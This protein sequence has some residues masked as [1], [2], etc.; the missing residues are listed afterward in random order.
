M[1]EKYIVACHLPR[2]PS[3]N[4]VRTWVEG[5]QMHGDRALAGAS[6]LLGYKECDTNSNK[7]TNNNAKHTPYGLLI[8]AEN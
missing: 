2:A 4:G 7:I 1:G 8:L 3:Y 6:N 5:S